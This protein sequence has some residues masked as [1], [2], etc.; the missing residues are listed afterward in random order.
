MI[1]VIG[2]NG[3]LAKALAKLLPQAHFTSRNEVDIC[4]F[5]EVQHALKAEPQFIINASGF[6][7]VD[8][9]ESEP[10]K[11]RLL[12]AIA[13]ENL[14]EQCGNRNIPLIHVSTDFV[15]DGSK[16]GPYF[17][18]DPCNP[19][20]VYGKTKREGEERLLAVNPKATIVRTSWLYNPKIVGFTETIRKLM[21]QKTELKIV[22]DQVGRPTDVNL[23]A[24]ALLKLKGKP[25]IYH[26][27][28]E[29]PRS[30]YEWALEVWRETP[31]ICKTLISIPSDEYPTPARR[32]TNS[33]L[34]TLKFQS[35]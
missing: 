23:L 10:E 6:T 11:A 1:W 31:G 29:A 32:P 12:N 19:L 17:E 16:E 15:F 8:R 35:L 30:R 25:G 27:A 4:N 7:E 33:V 5:D 13:V 34:S 22:N 9:A 28:S 20:S 3:M 18:D 26:Y 21:E 14:G 24:Q 2:K